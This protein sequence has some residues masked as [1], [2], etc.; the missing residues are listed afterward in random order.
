MTVGVGILP[1]SS[2]FLA[3]GGMKSA[4]QTSRDWVERFLMFCLLSSILLSF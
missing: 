4:S 2:R 3:Y 1:G